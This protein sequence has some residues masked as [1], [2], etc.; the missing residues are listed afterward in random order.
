MSVK[1]SNKG[2]QAPLALPTAR[3][4][5]FMSVGKGYYPPQRLCTPV[6]PLHLLGTW[7]TSA[8]LPSPGPTG[9]LSLPPLLQHRLRPTHLPYPKSQHRGFWKKICDHQENTKNTVRHHLTPIRMATIQTTQSKTENKTRWWRCG[10]LESV[11]LYM[12]GYKMMLPLWETVWHSLRKTEN[13]LTIGS[14]N[15]TFWCWKRGLK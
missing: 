13:R 1:D 4:S 8:F 7:N 15:S 14:S 5:T 12:W 10:E 3:A 11:V 2:T 6:C 9:P